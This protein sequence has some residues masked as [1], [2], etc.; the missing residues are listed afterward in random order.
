MEPLGRFAR[1]LNGVPRENIEGPLR[2]CMA[3]PRHFSKTKPE[4]NPFATDF[5]SRLSTGPVL[6][7]AT[8]ACAAADTANARRGAERGGCTEANGGP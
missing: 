2:G 7:Q 1:V 3:V 8:S 4:G 6:V 5:H